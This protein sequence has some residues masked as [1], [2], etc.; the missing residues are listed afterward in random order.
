[1]ID[2]SLL[3]KFQPNVSFYQIV[4]AFGVGLILQPCVKAFRLYCRYPS[5]P[6]AYFVQWEGSD[7]KTEPRSGTIQI[8]RNLWRGSFAVIAFHGTGKAQW[9][10]E[11]HLSLDMKNVGNGVFWHVDKDDGVGDQKFRYTPEKRQFRVQGIT[12]RA[13]KPDPFFHLWNMK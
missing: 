11:M 13:G 8:K 6:G 5:V 1:M 3:P 2:D 4:A 7:G 9:K 10:G 12:F